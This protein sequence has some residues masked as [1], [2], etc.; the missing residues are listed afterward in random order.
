MV[1]HKT[2]GGIELTLGKG[3]LR[4]KKNPTEYNHC[5]RKEMKG[6]DYTDRAS[7][8]AGFKKAVNKC[9]A[10]TPAKK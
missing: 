10:K 4:F 2:V 1:S 9:K 6:K 8:R 7:V 5:I 3:G